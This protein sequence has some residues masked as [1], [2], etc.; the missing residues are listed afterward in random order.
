MLQSFS[1]FH[2]DVEVHDEHGDNKWRLTR[3]YG[4]PDER[5]MNPLRIYFGR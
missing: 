3:F 4:H 5:F 1:N 2:I